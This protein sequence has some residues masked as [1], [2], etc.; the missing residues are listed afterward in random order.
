[1][2][3]SFIV[4]WSELEIFQ[5]IVAMSELEIFQLK[6]RKMMCCYVRLGCVCDAC[7][8][9]LMKY[10]HQNKNKIVCTDVFIL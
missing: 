3:I 10:K 8:C 7:R 5:F 4:S 6:K 9:Q 1:M 2:K